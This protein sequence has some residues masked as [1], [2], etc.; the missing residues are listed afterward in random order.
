M[1][2]IVNT[3]QSEAWN[4][5]EGRH[6][7]GN[8]DR[9]DAVNSG[10]N[11]FLLDAAAIGEHDRVLDVGCGN[12]QLTRLAAGLARHGHATGVDL[13]EPMLERARA[14][15]AEERVTNVTFDRGDAQI[16]PFPAGG[17]DVAISRFAIMFFAD[18]VAAFANIGRALRPGGRVAFLSLRSMA[19]NDLGQVFAEMAEHLPAP[20]APQTGGPGPDSLS[21]PAH[22]REVLTEA[23]F[24]GVATTPVD[25]PQIW[26][27]DAADAAAFLGAWGP[28]QHLLGQVDPA[29]AARARQA[30]TEALLPFEHPGAV[31]LRGGGLLITATRP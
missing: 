6:W 8:H 20:D 4:G 15:A 16:H 23:G 2:S 3:E 28:V 21:D 12:G 9:Y 18:P 1:H 7:A 29:T 24:T 10:F 17:F 19:D 25:A 31:R 5:Y 14:L 27:R 30:L 26:G 13:S 11:G 22:V